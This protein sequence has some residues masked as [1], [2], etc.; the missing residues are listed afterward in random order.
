[1]GSTLINIIHLLHNIFYWLLLARVIL[2]FLRL[3]RDAN[4]TLL[5]IVRIVYRL[6]EPILAPIR[7]VIKP[8]HLG[9][10]SYLDLSPI[11]ALLLLGVVRSLLIHL[12]RLLVFGF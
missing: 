3:G 10:G 12:V 6:T 9:G 7:K 2:S 11:V 1:M 5:H 4:P 8:V